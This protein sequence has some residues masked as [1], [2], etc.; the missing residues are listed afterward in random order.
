MTAYWIS[1]YREISDPAKVAAYAELAGPAIAAAGGRFIARG[2]PAAVFEDGVEQRS[3]IVEFDDVEAATAAYASEA[4]AE[5]LAAL[6][7]GA[8]RDLRIVPGVD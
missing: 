6:G 7:D 2:M 4:Y 1:A 5:A 3:V 8:V